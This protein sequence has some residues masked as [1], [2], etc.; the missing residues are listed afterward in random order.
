MERKRLRVE[1]QRNLIYLQIT[2]KGRDLLHLHMDVHYGQTTLSQ[3]RPKSFTNHP[4]PL[5]CGCHK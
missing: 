5:P 3:N 2:W 1:S 4:L